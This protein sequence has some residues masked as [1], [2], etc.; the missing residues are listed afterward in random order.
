MFLLATT[1]LQN[2]MGPSISSIFVALER[3]SAEQTC[4]YRWGEG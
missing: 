3:K 1:T 4:F 2:N